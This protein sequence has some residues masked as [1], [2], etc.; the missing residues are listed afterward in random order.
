V[1][2]LTIPIT[3]VCAL[4]A[5]DLVL[6]LLGPKWIETV[7]LFGLLSPTILSFAMINPLGWLM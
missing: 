5:N 3:V 2:T 1:V 4:F 7:P 6:V